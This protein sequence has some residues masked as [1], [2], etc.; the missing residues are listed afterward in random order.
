MFL[1]TSDTPALVNPIKPSSPWSPCDV[2]ARRPTCYPVYVDQKKSEWK[3]I[4]KHKFPL[5]AA[6]AVQCAARSKPGMIFNVVQYV[7]SPKLGPRGACSDRLG[8]RS[9]ILNDDLINRLREKNPGAMVLSMTLDTQL[10][11]STSDIAYT[12]NVYE[13]RCGTEIWRRRRSPRSPL[14]HI[15][16][17][18]IIGAR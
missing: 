16:A 5:S 13:P 8:D 17:D 6:A 9:C 2:G 15:S 3:I 4:I 1:D 11:L 7:L 18:G 14:R 12:I 10:P